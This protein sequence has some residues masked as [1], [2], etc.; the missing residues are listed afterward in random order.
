MS[1]HLDPVRRPQVEAW[2]ED[3]FAESVER[4]YVEQVE[5]LMSKRGLS[6]MDREIVRGVLSELSKVEL[7]Q[8]LAV[9]R[10]T[11][12]LHLERL[13]PHFREFF[14]FC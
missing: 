11:L 5:V 1:E 8:A 4:V 13:Q 6:G 10:S 3:H 12:D 7:A 2:Q 14:G 9:S